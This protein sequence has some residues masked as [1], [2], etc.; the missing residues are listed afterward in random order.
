MVEACPGMTAEAGS[1]NYEPW[2]HL[3]EFVTAER[4]EMVNS[5]ERVVRSMDNFHYDIL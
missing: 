5:L 3:R 1:E 4:R 2:Q